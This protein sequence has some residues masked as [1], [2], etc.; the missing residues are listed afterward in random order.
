MGVDPV[1][2][3]EL[4]VPLL[5]LGIPGAALAVRFVL[6]PTLREIAEAIR[7][8]R[9][10]LSPELERRLAELEEGQRL[11][12]QQLHTLIEA[13]R[14]HRELESGPGPE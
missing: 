6:R 3:V 11:V 14:F 10:G 7:R 5:L 13:E 2:L 12:E 1:E 9:E 4:L 8:P